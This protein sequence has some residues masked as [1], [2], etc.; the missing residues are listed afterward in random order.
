MEEYVTDPNVD[1]PAWDFSTWKHSGQPITFGQIIGGMRFMVNEEMSPE[2]AS[3]VISQTMV[4][5]WM[6]RN[7]NTESGERVQKRLL[8]DY[9]EFVSVIMLMQKGKYPEGT[10]RRYE[11]LIEKRNN[12][13]NIFVSNDSVSKIMAPDDKSAA[14]INPSVDFPVYDFN[15]WKQSGHLIT[16]GEIIGGMQF[17]I[18]KKISGEV[19]SGMISRTLVTHWNERNVN[20]QSEEIVQKR[21]YKDYQEFV[22]VMQLVNKGNISEAT[23]RRYEALIERRN[24]I[25]DIYIG[26]D[27]SSLKRKVMP[28]EKPIVPVKRSGSIPITNVD[29]PAID[30]KTWKNSGH[31][32]TFHE[33]IGGMQFMVNKNT[34]EEVASGMIAHTLVN[35]WMQRN[36]YPKSEKTVQKRV[37]KDFQEFSSVIEQITEGSFSETIMKKYDT[38]IQRRNQVYDIFVGSDPEALKRT[39]MLEETFGV[40]M[41]AQHYRYLEN[42]LSDI[43]R[44]DPRKLLSFPKN[45]NDYSVQTDQLE[46]KGYHVV[47]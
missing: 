20:T 17:M 2:M 45:D 27:S 9:Q 37:Y 26:N 32:I 10:L 28:E 40:N 12:I 23:R 47:P 7:V 21:L 31:L 18:D 44:G 4:N 22:S 42:Q 33:V 46:F 15:I 1:F 19:A 16:F 8:K 29:F 25:Y 39:K 14:K 6:L 35:H 3:G 36:V 30:S 41:E 43:P 38:L 5:H 11:A 24:N 34:S 13:Y